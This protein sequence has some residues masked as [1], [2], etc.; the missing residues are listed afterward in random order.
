MGRD[1]AGAQTRQ[2]IHQARRRRAIPAGSRDHIINA[3]AAGYELNWLLG[4]AE[5]ISK[6]NADC[7]RTLRLRRD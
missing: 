1:I 2:Q 3:L 7:Q 4:Q 5:R 6:L